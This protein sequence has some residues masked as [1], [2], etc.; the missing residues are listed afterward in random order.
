MLY[1]THTVGGKCTV[2]YTHSWGKMYCTVHTQL[3]TNVLMCMYTHSWGLMYV[4]VLDDMCGLH[5]IHVKN[6]PM[7]AVCD[8]SYV[9]TNVCTYAHTYIHMYVH[10]YIQYGHMYV[11]MYIQYSMDIHMCYIL[12]SGI[13][14]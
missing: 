12:Y 2:Q 10:M 4:H 11:H 5:C 1:S 9:H 7:S 14:Y 13:S 3:G 6:I 8:S